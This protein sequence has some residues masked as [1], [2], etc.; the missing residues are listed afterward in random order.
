MDHG[1]IASAA[2]KQAFEQG[3]IFIVDAIPLAV[4]D[5]SSFWTAENVVLSIMASCSPSNTSLVAL[6]SCLR[7]TMPVTLLTY[8]ENLIHCATATVDTHLGKAL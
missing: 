7:A 2:V 3:A 1:F 5:L 6:L 8:R 4:C